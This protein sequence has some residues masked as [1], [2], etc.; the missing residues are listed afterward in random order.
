M[1]KAAILSKFK[2]I[3]IHNFKIPD[4]LRDDQVLVKIS[5]TG[6]CGSQIKEYLGERGKDNYLPHAF[7]H[8][9]VGKV[10]KIGKKVKKV[11]LMDEVILSWIKGK[12]LDYGG[13]NLTSYRK[14]KINFGPISTFS[15]Y[16]IV[17]ENRVFLKPKNMSN[18]EAVLYGCA[19]P[20]GAG[21]VINQLK[22]INEKHKVCLI[23]V[24]GVGMA[25][26]LA[27]LKKK[28]KIHI[29]E[30]NKKKKNFLKKFKVKVLN[31]NSFEIYKNYFDFCIETSG[32]TDLI[33][34]GF[35]LIKKNGKL[36]FASHPK[37]SSILKLNP[38]DFICGK[39][40]FG[41][42]GGNS[43]LDKDIEKIF[44]FFEKKNIFTAQGKISF[45]KLNQINDAF[46]KV[47]S[48]QINRAVIKF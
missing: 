40:L 19:I 1:I 22:E 47:I 43:Q 41:S 44:N 12:G 46:K 17:S 38:Y 15:N 9:A 29:V 34:K 25:S 28:T 16:A 27:L 24:G 31:E 4:K 36:I 48:G 32:T 26:L 37:N 14:K 5:Y 30:K 3:E 23:G 42:W 7:G 10:I 6:I 35:D 18:V 20:T 2:K 13:F 11:S 45:F 33:E 39:K 8:E 21:L